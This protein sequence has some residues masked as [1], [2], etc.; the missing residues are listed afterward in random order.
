MT[1]PQIDD[2]TRL[3]RLEPPTGKVSVI[4]DTD[5]ANEIDDQFVL[6]WALLRPDAID[7]LAVVCEPFSFHRHREPLLR[8]E[9]RHKGSVVESEAEPLPIERYV[10]WAER[11][12]SLGKEAKDIDFG[13]PAQGVDQSVEETYRVFEAAGVDPDGLVFRGADEY[14]VDETTP[15]GSEGVDRIVELARAAEGI[16]YIVAIG[17]VT[18][19]ASALLVAPD[20]ADKIVVVWTSGYPSTDDRSNKPSMNLVQDVDATRVVLESGVPY[21]YMPG[22]LIGQQLTVSQPDMHEWVAGTGPLGDLLV[23]LYDNNPLYEMFGIDD[24]FARTW[25][26]WDLIC[27]AW[28]IDPALVTTTLRPT[29]ELSDEL[30]WDLQNAEN[31]PLMREAIGVNRDGIFRDLFAKL[32]ES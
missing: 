2:A 28:L 16:V 12:A 27:L 9:K 5:M 4:L 6:A 17:C 13:S 8:A 30:R 21:V 3:A 14:M 7:L 19:I 20:I 25:V 31:R 15:V 23:D 32:G 18:N 11:L 24:H 22:Y 26:I 10:L 1:F 29:P